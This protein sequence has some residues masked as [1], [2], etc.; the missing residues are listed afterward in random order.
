MYEKKSKKIIALAVVLLLVF[1]YGASRTEI[2]YNF[3]GKIFNY[4]NN[5]TFS[6]ADNIKN[7]FPSVLSDSKKCDTEFVKNIQAS[8]QSEELKTLLEENKE[9]K[10]TVNFLSSKDYLQNKESKSITTHLLGRDPIDR[11]IFIIDRGR[12]DGLLEGMPVVEGG[13]ALIGTLIEVTENYS[14]FILITDNRS[15]IYASINNDEKIGGIVEGNYNLSV[16]MKLIPIDKNIVE[17]DIIVTSGT[18]KLIPAGLIIGKVLSVEKMDND[19]FQ[20][21]KITPFVDSDDFNIITVIK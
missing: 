12:A 16:E 7:F 3:N 6:F 11:S 4:Y 13:G 21:A 14:H 5:K 18:D 8:I 9:L 15:K 17:G 20:T 10:E 19:I 1:L 2:L